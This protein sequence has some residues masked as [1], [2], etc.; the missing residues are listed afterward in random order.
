[1]YIYTYLYY[2]QAALPK[3]AAIGELLRTFGCSEPE[4]TVREPSRCNVLDFASL[5]AP[6]T[7]SSETARLRYASV[8]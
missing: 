3:D 6:A 5:D 1:M 8:E 2:K 7:A 4:L